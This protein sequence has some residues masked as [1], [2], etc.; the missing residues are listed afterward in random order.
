M[1]KGL[2][3]NLFF[4][5]FALRAGLI[6]ESIAMDAIVKWGSQPELSL[7]EIL[8]KSKD[9]SEENRALIDSLVKARLESQTQGL[10]EDE[11]PVENL[12]EILTKIG[13]DSDSSHQSGL[14]VLTVVS[15]L[16]DRRDE[17][18]E[19]TGDSKQS[20]QTRFTV[21][22]PLAEGG[23]GKVSVAFDNDLKRLVAFKQIQ[24]KLSGNRELRNRFT[25]EAEITGNLEHPGIVP[26]YALG[27]HHDG[28]PFYA[29][30]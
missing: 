4:C 11:T 10:P 2:D 7:G 29:M 8:V 20:S 15:G 23:L 18:P 25:V 1:S 28:T 13:M 9:L 24:K 5:A 16:S 27:D 19:L 30:K 3:Q 17:P 26:I 6:S 22:R 12:G 21:L 14:D